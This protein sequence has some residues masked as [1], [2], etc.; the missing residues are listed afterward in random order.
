MRSYI[1]HMAGDQKRAPNVARLMT[2]LPQPEVIEAVNGRAVLEAGGI[3]VRNGDLHQPRYPF[4]LRA[5]EIGCFLSHRKCWQKIVDST[6]EFGLIVEDDL[7]LDLTIWRDAIALAENSAT[8]ESFIRLPAKHR[9]T[10]TQFIATEGEAR[11]FLPRRIGLQTVAQVVG[12]AAAARLL[13]ATET[14]D[15]PVDTFLQ[16]HWVHWQMVHTIWPN[17]ASELT[18]E[19]GGS[20]IQS[21][22]TGGKIAREVKR[23]LYRSQVALRPQK[24]S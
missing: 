10:A 8:T 16:M 20:T 22:P 1:I 14:L 18:E 5:G 15:R 21:R 6:D 9:E 12:K 4:A 17:G 24:H 3:T 11:L 13:A 23:A 2:E 7:A 19:L